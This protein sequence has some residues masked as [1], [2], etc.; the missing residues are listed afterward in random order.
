[1]NT[2]FDAVGLIGGCAVDDVDLD[3]LNTLFVVHSSADEEGFVLAVISEAT[4]FGH[5]VSSK[6]WAE[7]AG[8]ANSL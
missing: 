2:K 6:E 5:A 1:M 4:V 3:Y 8:N 7:S